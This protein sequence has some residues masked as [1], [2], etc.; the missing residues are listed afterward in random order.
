MSEVEHDEGKGEGTTH[1]LI[2]VH[3]AY[4]CYTLSL[5]PKGAVVEQESQRK[6]NSN[7]HFVRAR[8]HANGSISLSNTQQI[9]EAS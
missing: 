7:G 2:P 5:T 9:V 1:V 4:G 8:S 3:A 6:S